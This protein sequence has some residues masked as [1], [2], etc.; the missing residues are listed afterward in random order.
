MALRSSSPSVSRPLNGIAL[1]AGVGG[2]ELGLHIAE[3]EFRTVCYVER[4]VFP[5]ATLVARMAD[6]AM[7]NAPIWSD[8]KTFDGRPWRGKVHILAGGYPCQ[9]FSA[10]GKQRGAA[11]PRHLWPDF[12]RIIDEIRPEWCFFENVEGHLDLGATDVVKDLSRLG[13]SVKAGLFSAREVGASH[14][15][16]RLYIVAH[17]S[18]VHLYQQC[19]HRDRAGWTEAESRCKSDWQTSGLRAGGSNV[20]DDMDA[21]TGLGS[22]TNQ[23]VQL[24]PFPPAPSRFADWAEVLAG[25]PDVQPELFGLDD[26]MANRVERTDCAGNGVVPLAAA[27]AWRTLKA[28]HLA[29]RKT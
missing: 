27:N 25:R 13:Y 29:D 5:A 4:E 19:G 11:D 7:D 26:G 21:N 18:E 16:R 24:P 2:L 23:P 20:D 1:C 6:K 8:V 9:P 28:A 14:L 15:R 12:S 3:P 22:F 17:A 10:A